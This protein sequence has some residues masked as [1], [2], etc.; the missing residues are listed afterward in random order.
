MSD[1]T[2]ITNLTFDEINVGDTANYSR[3]VTT[4]EVEL[5]AAVS[6]DHNPVHLDPEYAATTQ[7][8]ECIAHGMLTGAFISAAI[9]MELPGPGTIYLGQKLQFRSPVTLGDTLTVALEITEKHAS[10]P[11]LTISTIVNNQNG[12]EVCRGEATVMAP[13]K[14]E[15]VTVVPPPAVQLLDDP[16]SAATAEN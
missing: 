6:G 2:Q 13:G 15:T 3:L 1:A 7:F 10:K 9:A 11:W 8:G 4:R 14:K 5:F 16:D 12:K